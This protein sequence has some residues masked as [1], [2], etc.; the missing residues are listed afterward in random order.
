MAPI[1]DTKNGEGEQVGLVG[2][3]RGGRDRGDGD[4]GHYG[5]WLVND[6]AEFR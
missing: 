2:R 3:I 4:T 5:I 6:P 1:L